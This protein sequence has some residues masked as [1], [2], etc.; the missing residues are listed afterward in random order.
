MGAGG[1]SRIHACWR[2]AVFKLVELEEI[3]LIAGLSGAV[4]HALRWKGLCSL[5]WLDWRWRGGSWLRATGIVAPPRCQ[6]TLREGL[7][8][9]RVGGGRTLWRAVAP[10]ALIC[11]ALAV[12]T[13]P[14]MA[15]KPA[16]GGGGNR[17]SVSVGNDVSYPQ[18]SRA[19]PSG[20]AFGIVGLNDGLA[21]TLNPCLGTELT[22]A[23]QSTGASSQPRASV[24]VNTADPGNSYNGQLI[25][26]WPDSGATP[27]GP[28]QPPTSGG[29]VGQNSTAC[30][31]EYG[32]QKAAQDVSW[33]QAD[34]SK[35]KA[36]P[37]W[38][39][40]ETANTW[41]SST[42]LNDADLQGMVYALQQAGVTSLGA[43][44]TTSQWDQITG[45]TTTTAAGS[46]YS[47]SD[48][49]PGA[50]SLSGAERNCT[51]TPFTG[52]AV[53]VTQWPSGQYDGDYACPG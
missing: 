15:A 43:Y 51:Q 8:D 50:S 11:A 35:A 44:S 34:G 42:S 33:L 5:H 28:C 29:S 22:W 7:M 20:Q 25:A 13:V 27:D 1:G 19:L 3:D 21:N 9:R 52:G 40:V 39:D 10:I 18:C 49:I 30:A 16:R 47:L 37:W 26:D 48:W 14:A 23:V 6:K 53:T 24:Y 36:F 4:R 41:Q 46:L 31:W 38:L 12:T 32:N 45:G 17:S 2:A